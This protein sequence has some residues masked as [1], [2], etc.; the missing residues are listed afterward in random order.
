MFGSSPSR[1]TEN[2]ITDTPAPGAASG[3]QVGA[4]G[5]LARDIAQLS[6][7][8]TIELPGGLITPGEYD[9][10]EAARRIPFPSDLR[11]RRCLDV[12]THDG[13]WA[14]EMERRGATEVLA[15]DLDDPRQVD[16]SEPVPELSERALADRRE[17]PLAFACAHRALGSE[18]IRRDL[19]VY[20]LGP[21]DV[22]RFDFAF[23]GTL[24]LHLRDPV[25]ALTAVRDVLAPGGRLLINEAV[26]LGLSLLHP[27]RPVHS[28]TLLPGRPFHWVPNARGVRR[29]IEKAGLSVLDAGG[30]YLIPPG[31]G[32]ARDPLPRAGTNFAQRAV[33][34]RGMAHAWALGEAR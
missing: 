14:F 30:P 12:G 21:T 9:T 29:Y 17:R 28:L 13:F 15:I 27:R 32:Y 10:R 4:G 8:H 34:E 33:H 25:L 22:G 2:Q 26:L 7:Y 19:S 20:R 23:V 6:W 24:L 18:V 5:E 16:F 3:N 1:G 11:G 31:P